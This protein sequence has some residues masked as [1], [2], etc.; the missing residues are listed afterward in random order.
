MHRILLA[1][2]CVNLLAAIGQADPLP[3]TQPLTMEG[4][5]ASEMVAGID[6]FLLRQIDQTRAERFN[7]WKSAFTQ[8]KSREKFIEQK[9]T[10]L[11][12]MLGVVDSRLPF[13]EFERLGNPRPSH[14]KSWT[15]TP[16]RWPVL[17]YPG[18][19]WPDQPSIEGE[20]LLLSP[21]DRKPHGAFIVIPDADQSPEELAGIAGELPVD[22]QY[23]R[24]LVEQGYSVLVPTLISRERAKRNGR[25]NLTNRE[26]L[27]RSAFV[28]GRHLVGYEVQT[29]IAGVDFLNRTAPNSEAVPIGVLGTGEGGMIALYTAALDGRIDAVCVGGYFGPRERSWEEPISRNVF[30]RLNHFG[31][32]E[33]ATMI[34]P[35]TLIVLDAEYPEVEIPG[36][37][38]APAKLARV[39][40]NDV[41]A[42]VNRAR[43]I[44]PKNDGLAISIVK[45]APVHA[46][47]E[48][49]KLP[50]EESN[51]N[52]AA[53]RSIV[54]SPSRQRRLL[55]NADR[56][57]QWV[58]RESPY[59]REEFFKGLKTD[60]L[61]DYAESI[62]DYRTAF[63]EDVIGEFDIEP[64]PFNPRSRT[65]WNNEHWT[66]YEVVLDVFPDVFAYGVLLMPKGIED[67]EKRPVVVCQHGLEGR[68]TDTFLDD[69]RAYHD[70]AAKLAER[71]FIVFAPQ[72]PYLFKDRFRTLQR[73]A[74]PLGRSLF[75]IIVPQH[76]QIVDWLQ[77]LPQVD[78]D[79]IGFYGLS[80]G[81]KSAMRIPAL[82]TD[83]ALSIC[84]A[85]FNEWVWK[86]AST[87]AKHSYVWTGE[88]EI[89]EFNLGGTFNYSE[90]AALIA[91]RP[92]MVERGHF[93]G[94]APDKTVGAEFA[95]VRRLYNAK[96][97]I[98]DR[99]EI[100]WFVGPH[101]IN[102][103]GTF[104]FLHRHLQW[105]KPKK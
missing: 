74:N 48:A 27:Y 96:L 75:S 42:E 17:G 50:T 51:E 38:G 18:P 65:T 66:G 79:R 39:P 23:A 61:E 101:T 3:E 87:R 99:C 92:F 69:H 90:M 52:E 104:D 98:G 41:Q 44:L 62:E 11:A 9:R 43:Q 10:A 76:Q 21:I 37:G 24:Q 13:D 82:V 67:G 85:D 14:Q 30:G 77:T 1:A 88:Y 35:R 36:E 84:S 20:G 81:G 68:P 94:V 32:A 26:F 47:L 78:P 71:G 15:A 56:H 5:L 95:K 105:P 91:P 58:L 40:S 8:S 25:A 33:I 4:D 60:S 55:A 86:N 64:L 93:D 59:V 34:A 2:L 28:L 46:L 31:D 16:V 19:S 80:Y 83:Y 103:K 49:L 63:R 100:E 7:E 72:N 54:D 53:P 22:R 102:A 45:K 70:Y 12:K 57:N 97:G 6:R 29:V 73:K 89:Y